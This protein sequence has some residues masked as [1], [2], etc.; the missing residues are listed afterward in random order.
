MSVDKSS[1]QWP[2]KT[3]NPE[4]MSISV[5]VDSS[6]IGLPFGINTCTFADRMTDM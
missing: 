2:A 3:C 6:P 1:K 5:S 4:E